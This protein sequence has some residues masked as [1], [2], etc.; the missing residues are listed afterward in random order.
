M[1]R[2]ALGRIC[3]RLLPTRSGLLPLHPPSGSTDTLPSRSKTHLP[4]SCAD[5]WVI[6]D[7]SDNPEYSSQVKLLNLTTF[8]KV[9]FLSSKVTYSQ[10]PRNVTCVYLGTTSLSVTRRLVPSFVCSLSAYLVLIQSFIQQIPLK[11]LC[12]APRNTH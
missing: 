5:F 4:P 12:Y 6:P 11:G 3:L 1:S 2:Q 10:V 8:L 9:Y 7:P